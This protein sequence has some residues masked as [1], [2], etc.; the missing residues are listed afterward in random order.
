MGVILILIFLRVN[1]ELF[2]WFDGP[3]PARPIPEKK[4]YVYYFKNKNKNKERECGPLNRRKHARPPM[5]T[6]HPFTRR[7][8]P[9]FN[10]WTHCQ[11]R[12]AHHAR[13]FS[14][15][16]DHL[17][18]AAFANIFCR[19]SLEIAITAHGK[20]PAWF[21]RNPWRAWAWIKPSHRPSLQRA[22]S[23]PCP[24]S[25]VLGMSANHASP[26]RPSRGV[27]YRVAQCEGQI[28]ARFDVSIL[29]PT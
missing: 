27:R 22:R 9:C 10:D 29:H 26:V 23:V 13:A 3:N 21:N 25:D 18:V 24:R 6:V 17:I 28:I 16:L 11:G 8:V 14:R 4:W 5:R 2:L 20:P 19:L 15:I 7:T 1:T 12:V